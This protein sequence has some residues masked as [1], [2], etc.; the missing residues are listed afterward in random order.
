MK[1][2][3]GLRIAGGDC[4]YIGQTNNMR[5]RLRQ[6]L[7]NI[8]NN[9]LVEDWVKRHEGEIEQY[10]IQECQDDEADM[11]EK[12]HI[13]HHRSNG[14]AL[15]NIHDGGRPCKTGWAYY[16]DKLRQIRDHWTE[17]QETHPAEPEDIALIHRLVGMTETQGLTLANDRRQW[18]AKMKKQLKHKIKQWRKA[19]KK[20][21]FR[22]SKGSR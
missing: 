11:C 14:F 10:L 8:G 4:R 16:I 12:T 21:T 3:Y 20:R 17:C 2:I 6:I 13:F 9:Q 22:K 19:K 15:L 7:S 5:R 18:Q 1:Y